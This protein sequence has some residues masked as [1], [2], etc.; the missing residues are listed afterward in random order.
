MIDRLLGDFDFCVHAD[1]IA[2]V[3]VAVPQRP[4]AAGNVD[5][6]AM[7]LAEDDSYGQKFYS[8]LVYLSRCDQSRGLPDRFTKAGADDSLGQWGRLL[9]CL[10]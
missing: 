1:W 9:A 6:D 10:S 3:L 2:R 7:A 4:T 8:V 5:A